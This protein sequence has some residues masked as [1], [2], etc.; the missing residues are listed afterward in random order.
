MTLSVEESME[1]VKMNSLC[2]VFI[3]PKSSNMLIIFFL[4]KFDFKGLVFKYI[5]FTPFRKF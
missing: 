5:Q 1:Q 3:F 2:E 4:E